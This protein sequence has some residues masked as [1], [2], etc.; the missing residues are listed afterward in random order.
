MKK[1]V[2]LEDFKRTVPSGGLLNPNLRKGFGKLDFARIKRDT[3]HPHKC[4][5]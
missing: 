4:K 2:R 1:E 5:V 3:L